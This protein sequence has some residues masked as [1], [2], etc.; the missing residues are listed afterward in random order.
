MQLIGPRLH[1]VRIITLNLKYAVSFVG[2]ISLAPLS[3]SP[4][5]VSIGWMCPS[6]VWRTP[7]STIDCAVIARQQYIIRGRDFD[8]FR[9]PLEI[10]PSYYPHNLNTTRRVGPSIIVPQAPLSRTILLHPVNPG[11]DCR[12]D[13]FIRVDHQS[14]DSAK[15]ILSTPYNMLM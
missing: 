7:V 13:V 5:C 4:H 14:L 2:D 8:C 6:D 3:G 10:P 12:D 1:V 11:A 15:K 9:Y